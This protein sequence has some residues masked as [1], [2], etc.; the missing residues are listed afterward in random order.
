MTPEGSKI[1]YDYYNGNREKFM[2]SFNTTIDKGGIR[3]NKNSEKQ[4]LNVT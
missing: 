3:W 4:P 2:T 1:G